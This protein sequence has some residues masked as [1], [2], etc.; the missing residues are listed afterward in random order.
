MTGADLLDAIDQLN[1]K[2]EKESLTF[3]SCR[4]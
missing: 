2:G 4:G 1:K 3:Q